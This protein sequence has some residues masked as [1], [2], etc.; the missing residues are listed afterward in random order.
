QYIKASEFYKVDI[1]NKSF[2]ADNNK[3]IELKFEYYGDEKGGIYKL[4]D[5]NWFYLP[6]TI[7]E[8]FIVTKLKPKSFSKGENNTFVVLIDKNATIFYDIRGHWAKDEINAF[9]RRGIISGYGDGTF[10]PNKDLSRGEF[11][12]ILSKVYKWDIKSISDDTAKKF[13]DYN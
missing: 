8:G 9:A 10:K 13:K 1:K 7:E 3:D 12:S 4:V 11:L 5:N 6:S 2:E